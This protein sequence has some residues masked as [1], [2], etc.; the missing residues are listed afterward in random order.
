MTPTRALV[1]LAALATAG[2]V[3]INS[4]DSKGPQYVGDFPSLEQQSASEPPPVTHDPGAPQPGEPQHYS[5]NPVT[6]EAPAG[7]P[8]GPAGPGAVPPAAP[9]GGGG[10]GSEGGYPPAG[11]PQLPTIPLPSLS[12]LLG[13][14]PAFDPASV[15]RDT[16]GSIIALVPCDQLP[17]PGGLPLPG[18]QPLPGGLPLP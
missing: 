3:V 18:G 7:A 9:P 14:L 11:P 4:V 17:G 10:T 2:Y 5:A 12:D 1:G 13:G 6:P 16:A 8:A 15:C